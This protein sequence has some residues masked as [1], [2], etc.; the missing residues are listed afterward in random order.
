MWEEDKNLSLGIPVQPQEDDEND[1]QLE[2]EERKLPPSPP[3]DEGNTQ[4]FIDD[5]LCSYDSD[6]EEEYQPMSN[7]N[8]IDNNF[9]NDEEYGLDMFYDSTLDD[10]PIRLIIL[11]V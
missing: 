5:K 8:I 10:G 3:M 4:D 7:E 2:N 1:E 9:K 11:H 6:D